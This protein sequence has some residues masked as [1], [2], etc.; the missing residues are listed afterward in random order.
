MLSV[1]GDM[2]GNGRSLE[3]PFNP[4]MGAG[5]LVPSPWGWARD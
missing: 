4:F 1:G 5:S 3:D 2:G